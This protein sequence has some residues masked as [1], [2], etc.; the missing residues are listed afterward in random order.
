MSENS[1]HRTYAAYLLRVWYTPGHAIPE[2]RASLTE[3]A[4]NHNIGFTEPEA[5][6]AFLQS[7]AQG[8]DQ[9]NEE[10]R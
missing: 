9:Q 5:L 6:V 7:T 3:V 8:R 2:W 4:T 10:E 1:S